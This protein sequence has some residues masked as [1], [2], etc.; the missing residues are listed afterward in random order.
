MMINTQT[1]A[2]INLRDLAGFVVAVSRDGAAALFA[3]L[4]RAADALDARAA[5]IE[6][7]SARLAADREAARNEIAEARRVLAQLD[8]QR[9]ALA[10]TQASLEAQR[11]ALARR[12]AALTAAE[13]S[14]RS[15]RAELDAS[16]DALR[17]R[18]AELTR[19]HEQRMAD[20]DAERQRLSEA[21]VAAEGM[22]ADYKARLAALRAA[23]SGETQQQPAEEANTLEIQDIEARVVMVSGDRMTEDDHSGQA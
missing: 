22:R 2:Q 11:Q 3:D 1:G 17:Q 20:L 4:E 14:L 12:E 6:Q 13:D 23:V 8:E 18:E 21:R 16:R 15:A 10:A 9:A 19:Q 7:E 5:E